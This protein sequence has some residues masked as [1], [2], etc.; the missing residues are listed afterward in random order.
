MPPT[1][2]DDDDGKQV[3]QQHA[4]QRHLVPHSDRAA[5]QC[6]K[7]DQRQRK[8]EPPP[9]SATVPQPTEA[10]VDPAGTWSWLVDAMT[11]SVSHYR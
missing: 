7:T 4:V 9:S 5:G 2:R 1:D 6:G 8:P 11:R 10:G 3:D